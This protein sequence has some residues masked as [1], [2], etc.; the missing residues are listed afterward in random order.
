MSKEK[1]Q[2]KVKDETKETLAERLNRVPVQTKDQQ[3]VK[4]ESADDANDEQ[5]SQVQNEKNLDAE[6]EKA[7]NEYYDALFDAWDTREFTPQDFMVKVPINSLE[8]AVGYTSL[9]RQLHQ[10]FVRMVAFYK[11][12]MGGSLSTDEARANAFHA[13]KN[14]DEAKEK[15]REMLRLPVE[16]LEF[17]DLNELHSFAPRVAERLWER[18]KNEGR[19]EFESGHLAA[20]ISFPEGYMKGMWNIARYLGVR[21][22]FI[23]DWKPQGGIEIALI[24]MLAQSWFQYQFWLEQTVKRSQTRER[25]MHPDYSDWLERRARKFKAKGWTDGYWDRPY[26]SEQQAVEH[27]AQM[28]DRFNRIFMRTLRQLRDFR[29]YSPVTINNPSQVNIANNGGQ[30]IN[31]AK[32]RNKRR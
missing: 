5:T 32:R 30:Q 20:N 1:R 21:E 31:V 24:D 25:E 28:A 8:S 22:S 23:D 7:N 10:S 4:T 17:I 3:P 2:T 15:F 27:A 19:N 12:P 14:A 16:N 26:V 18:T 13:C 6:I 11:S 9:L 29:R